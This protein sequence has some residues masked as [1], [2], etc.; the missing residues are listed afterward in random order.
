MLNAKRWDLMTRASKTILALLE[1][2]EEREPG[3]A[4]E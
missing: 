4:E 1:S 2:Q 3:R